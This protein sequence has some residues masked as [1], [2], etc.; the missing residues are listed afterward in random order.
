[1]SEGN[2]PFSF[3]SMG[4]S[5]EEALEMY[6]I[7]TDIRRQSDG[8]I[9][10]CGHS[11]SR[12]NTNPDNTTSCLPSKITCSCK[13]IHYVMHTDRIFHFLRKTHGNGTQHALMLGAAGAV[14]AGGR[15]TG[16]KKRVIKNVEL[17]WLNSGPEC[18]FCHTKS[19]DA[20]IQPRCFTQP[21]ETRPIT[22]E[23]SD[24][25]GKVWFSDGYDYLCCMSCWKMHME[26][27]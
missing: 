14:Q 3:D 19:P 1:M 23:R 20:K 27:A 24:G 2:T 9:C 4:S 25:Y 13:R 7:K 15:L 26:K 16:K 11:S 5:L 17:S 21:P 12:H 22:R 8:L 18:E 6:K 10:I